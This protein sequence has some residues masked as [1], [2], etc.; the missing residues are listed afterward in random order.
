MHGGSELTQLLDAAAKGDPAAVDTLYRAV[1]AELRHM[2]SGRLAGERAN[3]TLQATA[4]VDDVFVRLVHEGRASWSSRR[5]FYGAAA[6]SMKRILIDHARGK[7]AAKRKAPGQRVT[8]DDVVE[9]TSRGEL[10]AQ[11]LEAALAALREKHERAHEVVMLKFFAGR[12]EEDIAS[13]MEISLRTVQGDWKFA[14]AWLLAR[15]ADAS[16]PVQGQSPSSP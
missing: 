2:A 8:L 5:H 1:H 11:G 3:H 15:M 12:K 4:L 10:D 16:A 14:R 13:A 6:E 7:G 9:Q